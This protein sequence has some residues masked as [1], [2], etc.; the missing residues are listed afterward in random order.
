MVVYEIKDPAAVV[1][2]ARPRPL[3]T[4]VE[5]TVAVQPSQ[6]IG[7]LLGRRE[8]GREREGLHGRHPLAADQA[9]IRELYRLVELINRQLDAHGVMVHLV[10]VADDDGFAIDL[11]DCSDPNVCRCIQDISIGINDL[12]ILL[13][14]LTQQMG[15]MVD[16]VL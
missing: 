7:K 5:P 14:R 16:T 9:A 12:P 2:T 3:R 4:D 11:Y 6:V 1:S 8:Q 13:S 10:L 15:I